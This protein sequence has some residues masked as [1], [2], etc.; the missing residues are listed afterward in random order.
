MMNRRPAPSE[1]CPWGLLALMFLSWA[2]RVCSGAESIVLV[3]GN[4]YTADDRN[5]RAQAVVAAHG[6]ILYVGANADA[7]RRAPPG[8]RR[9]D[10]H[11]LTILPGLTDSHAHLAGIGFRELSFNLEGTASVADLKDRLR[12]RAK[13]GTPGEWLTGRGWI[14]SRW[15]PPTFP[16][17]TDLDEIASDRPVFLERADGH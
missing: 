15:T 2:A 8:A 9:M 11:G 3:S 6:R 16:G 10:M 7:L 1:P 12:E 17:R 4:V 5:S 13:Q 14:E